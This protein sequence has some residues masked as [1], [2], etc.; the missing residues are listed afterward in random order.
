MKLKEYEVEIPIKEILVYRVF[1]Q[2]RAEAIQI[3]KTNNETDENKLT[4]I[5]SDQFR[6]GGIKCRE[7]MT[8][9]YR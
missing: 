9:R 1:A 2:S 4:Q 7:V 3:C 6:P 5:C 8:N